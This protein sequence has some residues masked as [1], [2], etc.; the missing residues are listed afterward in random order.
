M[1]W[2]YAPPND[3]PRRRAAVVPLLL[4]LPLTLLPPSHSCTFQH[5]PVTTAFDVHIGELSQHLLR[6]YPVVMPG[7]LDSDGQCAELWALH[8]LALELERMVGV[9]GPALQPLVAKVAKQVGFL[10]ECAIRDPAG[11]VRLER[12]NVSQLLADLS[13][14]LVALQSKTSL[15]KEQQP[16]SFSNCS[17]VRCQPAPA[18][19]Q[20][21]FTSQRQEGSQASGASSLHQT[22]LPALLLLVPIL[23]SLAVVVLGQRQRRLHSQGTQESERANT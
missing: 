22:H 3:P 8:F 13:A 20:P 18:L 21:S 5:D 14:H 1:T 2:R 17:H 10:Q 7:N 6:D 4:L 12:A 15:A 19:P 11:C 23:G 16:V 9:A